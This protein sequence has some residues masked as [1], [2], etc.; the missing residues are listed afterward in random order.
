[1]RRIFE[2]SVWAPNGVRAED[3]RFRNIFRV[4]LPLSD[5]LFFYFGYIG[6]RNGLTSVATS[7]GDEWQTIWSAGIAIAAV[8]AFVGVA[9]PRLWLLELMGKI[10]LI[11][12][13]TVYIVVIT[14]N[15][16]ANDRI[17]AVSGLMV[18]LILLATWRIGDLA[19]EHASS[20][21]QAWVRL[22]A[23]ITR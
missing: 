5:V 21:Y 16:V 6:W 22:R 19:A 11:S 7:A 12:F 10:P 8:I 18:I 13:I 23:V 15:G 2:A 17:L 9:F 1:M 3:W 20:F 4:V 14:T